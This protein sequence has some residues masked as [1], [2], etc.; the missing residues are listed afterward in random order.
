M[1][2]LA[3]PIEI[4][5]VGGDIVVEHAGILKWEFITS[6]GDIAKLYHMGHYAPALDTT[7]LLSPQSYFKEKD[8]SGKFVMQYDKCQIELGNGSI[9]PLGMHPETFLPVIHGFNDA[10]TTAKSL[11]YTGSI[12][13]P[14]NLNLTVL[15]KELLRFHNKLGHLG[16]QATQ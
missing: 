5:G 2:K 3:Q 1:F 4:E 8:K 10:M 16:M 12:L 6:K 15:Q 14:K 9:L 13:D 7:R 11:A